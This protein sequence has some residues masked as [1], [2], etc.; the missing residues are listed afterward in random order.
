MK[1]LWVILLVTG[2]VCTCM[3]QTSFA[4]NKARRGVSGPMAPVHV[5]SATLNLGIGIGSEYKDHY[6]NSP[7]GM[8]AAVEWG[9]WH[10]GPG[11][12]TLGAEAGASFSNGGY[13]DD[14]RSRTAIIAMRSAWHYGWK[15]KGLDTY[16]G[17]SGGVGFH[18]YGYRNNNRFEGDQ[19]IPVFGAFI[20]ASYFVAPRFGFNAEAGYDITRFQVGVIFKLK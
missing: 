20:G 1:K 17:F 18:H 10:A 8:K 15:V 11:T 2:A 16:G 12:I 7:F 14:Y 9:L 4:Q 3:V 19:V 5:G 13:Y 6:Y